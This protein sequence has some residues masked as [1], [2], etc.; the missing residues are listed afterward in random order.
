MDMCNSRSSFPAFHCRFSNFFWGITSDGVHQTFKIPLDMEYRV[1]SGKDYIVSG[2]RDWW[3]C[4][5]DVEKIKP[6]SLPDATPEWVNCEITSYQDGILYVR[7][8]GDE[9]AYD[10]FALPESEDGIEIDNYTGCAEIQVV[11]DTV[12]G[13]KPRLDQ[14]ICGLASRIDFYQ[15]DI[16]SDSGIQKNTNWCMAEFTSTGYRKPLYLNVSIG[17]RYVVENM[18]LSAM[19]TGP[20]FI[21]LDLGTQSGDNVASVLYGYTLT[22]SPILNKPKANR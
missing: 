9:T 20:F 1:D 6:P 21:T 14:S 11:Q 4:E 19:E 5:I 2:H 10:F 22:E 7:L 16:K 15:L 18:W 3:E 8:A 17:Q 12:I 13:W